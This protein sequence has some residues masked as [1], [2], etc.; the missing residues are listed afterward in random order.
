MAYEAPGRWGHFPSHLRATG[1]LIPHVTFRHWGQASASSKF[2]PVLRLGALE[3]VLGLPLTSAPLGSG[4][5][6][7]GARGVEKTQAEL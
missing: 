3:G 2:S 4:P 6:P 5:A 1:E 7:G